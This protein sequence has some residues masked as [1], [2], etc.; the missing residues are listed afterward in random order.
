MRNGMFI[1]DNAVHAYDGESTNVLEQYKEEAVNFAIGPG[2]VGSM[3]TNLTAIDKIGRLSGDGDELLGRLDIQRAISLLFEHSETDMVMAQTVPISDFWKDFAM[4]LSLQYQLKEAAPD[5]VHFVGAVDPNTMSTDECLKAIEH[6]VTDL[7]ATSIKFYQAS[8]YDQWWS[9]DD[10]EIAYPLYEKCQELG[11]RAVQFHKGFSFSHQLLS[12]AMRCLDLQKP[13]RDFPDLQIIVHHFGWPYVDEAIQAT[14]RFTN[15]SL[16]IAGLVPFYAIAPKMILDCL[17]KALLHL[18]PERVIYGSEGLVWP[19]IQSIIELFDEM[20]F[21]EEMQ[22]G[23]GYPE[24]T[25]E[26]RA[27]MFGGNLAR[28][29][30]I[31]IPAKTAELAAA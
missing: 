13:A 4:P 17:G 14:N 26:I 3:V 25:P 24:I 19:D 23:Y 16:S 30:G 22:A 1:F 10:R 15:I 2:S 5:R 21:S 12:D 6:Q 8:A 7:G 18:G 31:D 29:M 27:L 28:I 20:Q 9:A 11:V